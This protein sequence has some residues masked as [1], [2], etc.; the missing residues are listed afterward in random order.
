VPTEEPEVVS[1]ADINPLAEEIFHVSTDGGDL[2]W[3]EQAWHHLVRS[4]LV[5]HTTGLER[6]QVD[7]RAMAL[8]SIYLDWCA[9]V[10]DERQD[11]QPVFWL[12]ASNTTPI[13][14]GQLIGPSEDL[15]DEDDIETTLHS[16]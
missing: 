13:Q 5:G 16:P 9:V 11:D 3:A 2:R 1:W 14:I 6:A 10:H 7:I 8:G 15:G 12:E 4:G